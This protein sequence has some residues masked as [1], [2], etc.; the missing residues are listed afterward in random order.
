MTYMQWQEWCPASAGGAG[1]WCR[2]AGGGAACR[3]SSGGAGPSRS[4]AP[5]TPGS[6]PPPSGRPSTLSSRVSNYMLSVWANRRGKYSVIFN[7]LSIWRKIW[8]KFRCKR[9]IFRDF[10]LFIQ[11]G[12]NLG[13]CLP[14]IFETLTNTK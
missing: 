13:V 6:G 4:S 5:A 14:T 8:V 1:G 11:F 7:Y 2:S 9:E 3:R 10:Q 12:L